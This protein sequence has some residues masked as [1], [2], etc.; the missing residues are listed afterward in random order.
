[1]RRYELASAVIGELLERLPE[2]ATVSVVVFDQEVGRV[3][4][5]PTAAAEDPGAIRMAVRRSKPGMVGDGT[6]SALDLA[7]GLA[8][9]AFDGC[10]DHRVLLVTDDNHRLDVDP[11]EVTETV[12]AWGERGLELWTLSLGTLGRPAPVVE[13]LTAAGRG[14]VIY[15]D[16]PAEAVEP[17]SAALRATGAVAR[18]LRVEVDL[19]PGV[20]SAREV[21]GGSWEVPV[22]VDAGWRQVRLYALELDPAAAGPV[23]SVRWSFG[24]PVPGEWAV[25]RSLVV[26]AGPMSAAARE[27]RQR[28]FAVAVAE[29]LDGARSWRSVEL[30][31]EALV[32]EEGPGREWQ[33][34]ARAFAR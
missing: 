22:T 12:R 7:Y 17:L 29:A 8:G 1:V 19:G 34:W 13:A 31:G 5:P 26:E 15:A 32:H 23:A 25:E 11:E 33:A 20:R 10:A 14:A 4:L 6:D 24:S 2:R 30:A 16:T 9:A 18:D 28:V 3:M 21:S 27:L